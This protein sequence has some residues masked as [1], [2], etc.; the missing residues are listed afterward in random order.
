[1]AGADPPEAANIKGIWKYYNSTTETGRAGVSAIIHLSLR[2]SLLLVYLVLNILFVCFQ[3][4]KIT[5][6]AMGLAILYFSL[7][8]KPKPQADKK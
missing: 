4:A 5:L 2:M 3:A 6:A 7:K 8:P 1:M